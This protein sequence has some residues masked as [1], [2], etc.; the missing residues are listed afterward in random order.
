MKRLLIVLSL[1]AAPLVGVAN[2]NLNLA[3]RSGKQAI[4]WQPAQSISRQAAQPI[5]FCHVDYETGKLVCV[6]AGCWVD[7]GPG[8]GSSGQ[9]DVPRKLPTPHPVLP[10][11][12]W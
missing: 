10:P 7:P 4:G 9:L 11:R 5:C 2:A 8:T 3:D 6:P 12:R 1:V